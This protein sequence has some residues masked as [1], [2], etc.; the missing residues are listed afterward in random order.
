MTREEAINRLKEG[1]PFSEICDPTWDEALNMAI[2]AL[3]ENKEEDR[4]KGHWI[5]I[6]YVGSGNYMFECSECHHT[7]T[8]NKAVKV[9]YCWHCGQI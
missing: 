5:E 3:S 6:G 4:P 7:D 2:S 8:Q 9:N 1:E